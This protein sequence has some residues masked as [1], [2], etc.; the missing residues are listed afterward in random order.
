MNAFVKFCTAEAEATCLP[1]TTIIGLD[2]IH[3]S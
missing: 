2:A 3:P 1:M